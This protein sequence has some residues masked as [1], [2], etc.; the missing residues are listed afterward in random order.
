MVVRVRT[1][2]DAARLSVDSTRLGN[3]A[4]NGQR[5]SSASMATAARPW[6]SRTLLERWTDTVMATNSA[7]ALGARDDIH[8]SSGVDRAE[9]YAAAVVIDRRNGLAGRRDP[10][11]GPDLPPSVD[12]RRLQV[13]L[14]T[15]VTSESVASGKH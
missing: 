10:S 1:R 3:G 9:R 5:S 4:G 6:S 2:A 7:T 14:C 11:R 15:S 8:H 13:S 12:G